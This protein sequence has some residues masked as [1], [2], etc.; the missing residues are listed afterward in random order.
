MFADDTNISFAAPTLSELE[1]VLNRELRNVN[2]WLKVNKLSLNIAKTEC[3]M[4]TD[5]MVIGSRQRLN[6]NTDGNINIA[7]KDQPIKKV[8]E[9]ETLGMAI[10]Q[11]LAWSKHV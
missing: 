4:K 7:I 8:K 1:N 3:M 2:L 11:Y 5:F 9:T 6:V 10:D